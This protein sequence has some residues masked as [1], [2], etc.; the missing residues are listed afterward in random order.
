M[1]PRDDG[2]EQLDKAFDCLAQELPPV[3][4]RLLDWLRSPTTRVIR[5]VLG[6]MFICASF[7]WFLPVIG[8]ELL[9]LGLLLIAI[10]VPFLR[11]PIARMVIW[12]VAKWTALR[13]WWRRRRQ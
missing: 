4:V 5:L 12:I 7:F 3:A 2:Q 1:S 13:D 11:K 8:I 9:P 10:D 6:I